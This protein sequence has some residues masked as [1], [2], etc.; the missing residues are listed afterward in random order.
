M[1]LHHNRYVGQVNVR[2][3]V[4][5]LVEGRFVFDG[6]ADIRVLVVE[7]LE[8][9][10]VLLEADIDHA[11]YDVLLLFYPNALPLS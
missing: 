1:V 5:L 10:R 3:L 9:L 8:G 4:L 2:R 11:P 7:K 6:V